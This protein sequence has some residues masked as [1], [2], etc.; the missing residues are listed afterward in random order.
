MFGFGIDRSGGK[1]ISPKAISFLRLKMKKVVNIILGEGYN[2][3]IFQFN[4]LDNIEDE[5]HLSRV[6]ADLRDFLLSDHCHFIFLGN[7]VME[8]CFKSNNKLNDCISY[9]T[10][11]GPLEFKEVKQ[12]LAKRYET[13]RI[14]ERTPTGPVKDDALSIIYLLNDGNIRQ[15]FYS[16]DA[17][18]INSKRI[19]GEV[20]QLNNES[21]QKVLYS[22]ATE[23]ITKSIQPRSFDVLR[24]MLSKKKE[25]T[26]TEITTKLKLRIQNTSKYL[27]Q[28]KSNNLIVP[29][30]REG[31]KIYYRTVNEARW[32]LLPPPETGRQLGLEVD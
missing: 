19:L 29:I 18:L 23:R 21:L 25:V 8:S 15:I 11:L 12:I 32:L 5:E 26:N 10:Y 6:L 20:R 27:G 7:K 22:L 16:L 17:A 9:D 2:G 28:L 14:P 31:R 1:G 30:G 24:Y 13:F 4:N 3:I